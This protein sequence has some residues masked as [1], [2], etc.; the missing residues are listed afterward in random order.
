[1]QFRKA[2][3]VLAAFALLAGCQ[4]DFSAYA[5]T[6]T[7]NIIQFTTRKP[8]S[9]NSTVTVSGLGSSQSVVQIAYRPSNG[10]LYCITN[11]GFLCTLNPSTGAATVMTTAFTQTLGSGNNSVRL[12]SPVMSFDP[13]VDQLRVIT[14]DYNLRVNPDTGG[15]INSSSAKI[16]FDSSDSNSGKTPQLAGIVYQDPVA[17]SSTATL[18]ALDATTGSLLRIG[19]KSTGDVASADGGD[20]R[21]VGST[22]VSFSNNGGF[23]IEQANGDAYAVLQQSG[24]GAALFTVDLGSGSTGK[25]GA[26]GNGD[27]TVQSL[28]IVPGA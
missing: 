26:I 17:G 6:T 18:F 4:K 12:S 10:T 14:T 2:A 23:T 24:S 28:V 27:Q 8:T 20:L 22:G 25:V 3:L 5:L 19:D 1:M 9:I 13:V 16:A 15:L 21:T 11:D 7:G